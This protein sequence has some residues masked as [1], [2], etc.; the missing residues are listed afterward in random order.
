[1]FR[2]F[3]ATMRVPERLRSSPTSV[4]LTTVYQSRKT[5]ANQTVFS[6]LSESRH[7]ANWAVPTGQALIHYSPSGQWN[8]NCDAKKSLC[9]CDAIRVGQRSFRCN[10]DDRHASLAPKTEKK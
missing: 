9:L 1:M 2:E 10:T 5:H 8:S 6:G 7:F 3:F 4:G